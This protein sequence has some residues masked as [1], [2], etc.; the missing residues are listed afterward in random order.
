MSPSDNGAVLTDVTQ[1][2]ANATIKDEAANQR[3]REHGW[4]E[5]Q[6]YDYKSYNAGTREECE[7]VEAA[8]ELPAWASNA[9]KYEWKEEYGDVG[10]EHKELEKMLFQDQNRMESGIEFDKYL[11]SYCTQTLKDP[12]N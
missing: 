2:M 3:S 1:S 5:P 4:S 11:Y 7:A 8:H 9:I 12:R 6:K 10:P